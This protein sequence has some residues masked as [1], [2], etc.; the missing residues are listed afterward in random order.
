VLKFLRSRHGKVVAGIVLVLALFLTRPGAQRLRARIVRSISLALGRQV[1]VGSV[2]LRLLPQPGFDLR[3]FA[4]HEDPAFGAEPVLQSSDV[5]AIVRM[6]SLLRGRLEIARLSLSEPSLN[7]VRNSEGHWNLENLLERAARTPVAPTAKARSEIRPGF[8][9]IEADHGRINLKLG[10]EKKPYTLTEAN[11][12]LWQDSENTWGVRLKA[13]PTRT[14]FN[15]SDTGIL[16]VDGSWQR[17]ANLH[18]TP[19]NFTLQW[20]GAQ[21]GQVTKL[22]WGQ[23]KGWRGAI[24]FSAALTGSPEDLTV[25]ADASI[26]DFRRYD[27]AGGNA[28]RLAASCRAHYSS[29]DHVLSELACEAPIGEGA[30]EV[31]G[32]VAA[33]S[34]VRSYNLTM[35]AQSVPVQPLVEVARRVKKNVPA[36]IVAA[37]K[38][39]ARVTLRRE[40]AGAD[41][42]PVWQGGG[43]VQGLNVRSPLTS[44]RF[45]LDRIPF[46]VFS[47]ANPQVKPK[48]DRSRAGATGFN[49]Q[50]HVDIGPFGLALGRPA[51]ATVRGQVS[52][53]GYSLLV[54]GDAEVQRL[55]EVSQTVGLP[56]LQTSATGE[57]HISLQVG[58]NWAGF[59]APAVTGTAVLH[60]VHA[61]FRG[62][63]DPLEIASATISLTPNAAEVQKL[64]AAAVGN[65][66]RGSLTIP[67]QCDTPR[68]CP[69]RFDLHA[70]E[71]ATDTLSALVNTAPGK[72][73]WYRF[74]SS[75]AKASPT[76]PRPYLASVHAIGK[77]TADRI[78]IRSLTASRV[79]A[80]VELDQ[81][82]LRVSNL[83]GDVLGGRHTGEWR[84][85]FSADPPTYSGN[86]TLEKVALGQLAE[87]MHDGW[88][89]GSANVSYV[90]STHGW[91][92][93]E[94]LANADA[95]LQ[96]EVR[97]GSLPHL[98]LA[99]DAAPLHVNR[100]AGR[101]L[102]RGGKFEIE[103]GKL[104]TPAGIYQLSG[105]ASMTRVLDVK[106]TGEGTHGFDISGTLTQ[107]HVVVNPTAETQAA[108]KP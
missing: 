29:M 30:I 51:N 86:G 44:T 37:G 34:A 10:Q 38:L 65:T 26:Q 15:L 56:A 27:I 14:D 91:N 80:E 9:Y 94:L 60:S 89:T 68:A 25:N 67:R 17:A 48:A 12:A 71:I 23:D 81:G 103:Q 84:V 52:R 43:E 69:V 32:N 20:D 46:A 74:L 99:G 31:R 63:N 106:L 28:S 73:P 5:V 45:A 101:V 50:P 22:T 93:P 54:Q 11:F 35:V 36:D 83:R 66:W 4:I 39:D 21:L 2:T 95:S 7:L 6:S 98:T 53:S 105:T 8:P 3:N 59:A 13:Q 92:K 97:D 33:L 90:A 104:Q 88:I 57:V 61:R 108:L 79:S 1:D 70:D 47:D 62:L 75:P 41:I 18:E 87:A 96:M 76:Q 82:R 64:T 49:A 85:D 24:R 16:E 55:L 40:A 102:L 107:P 58:G 78:L 100:F 19:V 77:L 72:E 42:G